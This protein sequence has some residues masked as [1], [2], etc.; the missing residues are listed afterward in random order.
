MKQLARISLGFFITLWATEGM[1][2]SVFCSERTDL[3]ESLDH[4]QDGDRYSPRRWM[5]EDKSCFLELTRKATAKEYQNIY[6]DPRGVMHPII[7]MRLPDREQPVYTNFPPFEAD[8]WTLAVDAKKQDVVKPTSCAAFDEY[9]G[10]FVMWARAN[11]AL[12]PKIPSYVEEPRHCIGNPFVDAGYIA[13][14]LL[15]KEI[16]AL[17]HQNA[18]LA[19]AA[20][21]SRLLEPHSVEVTDLQTFAKLLPD[22]IS[23]PWFFKLE[24]DLKYKLLS[25]KTLEIN[26]MAKHLRDIQDDTNGGATSKLASGKEIGELVERH[27]QKLAEDMG[28]GLDLSDLALGAITSE[29]LDATVVKTALHRP[30]LI[31]LLETADVFRF[32]NRVHRKNFVQNLKTHNPTH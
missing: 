25:L 17:V 15:N 5:V 31:K 9:S 21:F 16:R 4:M 32:P 8:E 13:E 26:F 2:L 14:R 24:H 30:Y 29:R 18:T 11:A 22:T 19:I 1:A 23:E 6:T 10:I 12:W 28:H 3:V 20:E 27:A 7:L